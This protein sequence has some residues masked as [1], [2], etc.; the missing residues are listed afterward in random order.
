MLFMHY[1]HLIIGSGAGG[2]ATAYSLARAGKRVLVLEKGPD[3]PRDGSTLDV[4]RVIKEGEF[5][6]K[7]QWVNNAGTRFAPEEYFNWGGKTRWYGAALL[8][9]DPSE[10]R[11]DPAFDYQPWP[12]DY[13]DLEPYYLQA[14]QLLG[15]REFP[16]EPSLD[17]ILTGLR[18][19]GTDWELRPLPLGLAPQITRERHEAQHFDGFASIRGLK[20]DAE[21]GMLEAIRALPNVSVRTEAPVTELLRTVASARGLLG[22]RTADGQE[23][24]ADTIVLAAGA[25]HSPRLLE[26]YL[27]RHGLHDSLP[28]AAHVGRYFKRHFLT[29]VLA[30][31]TRRQGDLLRKTALLLS[32]RFPHSSV[33]PLGFNTDVLTE[34]LPAALP[35][36][37]SSALAAR[38]YGFFL[39]TEDGSHPAN[40]VRIANGHGL[41]ELDYEPARTPAS[42]AEHRQ[43]VRAF[44]NALFCAGFICGAQ[45]VPLAGTAHACGTLITGERDAV[46]NRHGR[47]H[48]LDNLFVADGSVL[49][50]SSRVNPSLTIYA[51]GLRLGERLAL[52]QPT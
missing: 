3:L 52:G 34:L 46:V 35:R 48:G 36:L 8:R 42:Q 24:R 5:K 38:A 13:A 20:G 51:W 10:F 1:D 44:R 18:R 30:F 47:V 45:T 23:Y 16:I 12:I 40:Q 26:A 7:E 25:L 6:S 4:R 19:G 43:F 17:A 39:Q 28:G 11:G 27:R 22:V 50:R 41:P 31:S 21:V 9:Y 15:V 29:A 14:E 49:P 32:R 37:L 33:Q 2:A